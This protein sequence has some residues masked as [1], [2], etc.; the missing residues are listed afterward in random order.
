MKQ[1]V[2]PSR[3]VIRCP[4]S[5]GGINII[6]QHIEKL[7]EKGKV[8]F[9]KIGKPLGRTRILEI[10]DMT[11]KGGNYK[12]FLVSRKAGETRV[13]DIVIE[14]VTLKWKSE[15]RPLIPDYYDLA[16]LSAICRCWFVF[17]AMKERPPFSSGE[18]RTLSGSDLTH[19]LETSMAGMFIAV[20][21]ATGP[22][23][24]E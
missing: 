21:A 2:Q 23:V 8:V 20:P 14:S 6:G 13:F 12:G 5:M 1:E 18:F 11:A 7:G 16:S 24:S 15:F 17:T 22:K 9:A 19:A 4:S 3:L 10:N